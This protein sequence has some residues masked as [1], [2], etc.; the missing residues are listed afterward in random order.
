MPTPPTPEAPHIFKDYSS[1]SAALT[2]LY[3][4]VFSPGKSVLS[5]RMFEPR[6]MVPPGGYHSPKLIA[7][8]L[9][10]IL[11]ENSLKM[12]AHEFVSFDELRVRADQARIR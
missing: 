9:Y 1:I 7:A 6:R 2:V 4:R 8:S 5:W 11:G 12:R 3:D 10:S